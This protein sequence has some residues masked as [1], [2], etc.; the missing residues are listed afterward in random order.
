M[1][2]KSSSTFTS[3]LRP[4][5]SGRFQGS[6]LVSALRWC[7]ALLPKAINFAGP[8]FFLLS[9]QLCMYRNLLD[10]SHTHIEK[11]RRLR[12]QSVSSYKQKLSSL[13]AAT[14]AMVIAPFQ[15]LLGFWGRRDRIKTRRLRITKKWLLDCRRVH[16]S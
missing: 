1:L 9:Q 8:S 6:L 3:G 14:S 12:A 16:S 13:E 5:S 2:H 7:C 15:L 4:S 10:S 11:R